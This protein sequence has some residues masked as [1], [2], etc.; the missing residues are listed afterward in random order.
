MRSIDSYFT[1]TKNNLLKKI[2][3]KD[4]IIKTIFDITKIL[5]NKKEITIKNQTIFLHVFGS[6]RSFI[7]SQ[8]KQIRENL[9]NKNQIIIL[10]IK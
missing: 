9:L 2:E 10:S 3:E 7:I 4:T 1:N 8:E 6:R 5:L